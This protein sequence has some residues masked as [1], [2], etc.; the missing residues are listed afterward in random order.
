VNMV[1]NHAECLLFF[2]STSAP[3]SQIIS[4]KNNLMVSF[5]SLLCYELSMKFMS[6]PV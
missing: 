5:T 1:I 3:G 4:K 2:D 6:V